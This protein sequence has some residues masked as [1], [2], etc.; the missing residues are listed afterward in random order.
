MAKT[1]ASSKATQMIGMLF[2]GYLLNR[3][4]HDTTNAMFNK[5]GC[6]GQ[7]MTTSFV[8]AFVTL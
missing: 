5:C 2:K 1:E 8:K 6:F 4:C 7:S 3:I